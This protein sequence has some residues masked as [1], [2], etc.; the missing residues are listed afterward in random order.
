MDRTIKGFIEKLDYFTSQS[1]DI[2]D[3]H[4]HL[5]HENGL[6]F[7]HFGRY[8]SCFMGVKTILFSMDFAAEQKDFT[9]RYVATLPE[10]FPRRD[11]T[12]AVTYIKETH[13]NI[14]FL[15]FQNFYSQT[16]FTLRIIRRAKFPNDRRNPFKLIAEEFDVMPVDTALFLND[17]RNTIHNNGYYFPDDNTDKE[18]DFLG[19][20][21]TFKVGKPID[22]VTMVDILNIVEYVLNATIKLFEVEDFA[23]HEFR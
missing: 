12:I 21:F 1:F 2:A 22:T 11:V 18:H 9:N 15:L 3:K 6:A 14:R 23:K 4:R 19:K 17:I 10:R 5:G 7:Y 16:E 13:M 20:K 8:V